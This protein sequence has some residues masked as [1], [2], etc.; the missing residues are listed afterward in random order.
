MSTSTARAEAAGFPGASGQVF[1]GDAERLAR[2]LCSTAERLAYD[3]GVVLVPAWHDLDGRG[4]AL[5]TEILRQMMIEG[6]LAA[7]GRRV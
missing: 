4:Q 1:A 2:A 7:S 6:R 5:L 3:F